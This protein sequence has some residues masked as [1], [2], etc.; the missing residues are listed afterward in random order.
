MLVEAKLTTVEKDTE[1][2]RTNECKNLA[3]LDRLS[4]RY[5]IMSIVARSDDEY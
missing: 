3:G 4:G 2:L 5:A 1:A